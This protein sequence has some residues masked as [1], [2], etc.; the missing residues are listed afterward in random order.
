MLIERMHEKKKHL[1]KLFRNRQRR[2]QKKERSTTRKRAVTSRD[3]RDFR[4]A[5]KDP[6]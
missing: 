5:N 1:I 6:S 2:D 3:E 4:N